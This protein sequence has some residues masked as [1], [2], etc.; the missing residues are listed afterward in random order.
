MT[1]TSTASLRQARLL[2]LM[3]PLVVMAGL[4]VLLLTSPVWSDWI[5][6]ILK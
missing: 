2:G 5:E 1:P 3:T 4:V 6:R